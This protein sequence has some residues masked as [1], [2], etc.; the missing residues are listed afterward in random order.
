MKLLL[1]LL[2]CKINEIFFPFSYDPVLKQKIVDENLDHKKL[3]EIIALSVLDDE[4]LQ[5]QLTNYDADDISDVQ[6]WIDNHTKL[7]FWCDYSFLLS[8]ANYL[9]RDMVILPIDPNDGH[10]DTGRI[11]IEAREKTGEP[12]YFL[13]Y[14]N[15]HF[16][17]IRPKPAL[18]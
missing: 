5:N 3:R 7:G 9:E 2:F 13:S 4:E 6:G 11:V 10:G 12:F 1:V 17:S 16:Q 15:V 14:Y 18:E 8:A